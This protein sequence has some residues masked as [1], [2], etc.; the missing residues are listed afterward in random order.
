MLKGSLTLSAAIVLQYVG[1]WRLMGWA[2]ALCA[3]RILSNVLLTRFFK[4]RISPAAVEWCRLS[5]NVSALAGVGVVAGWSL[6]LWI[7]VPFATLWLYGMDGRGRARVVVYLVCM[8]G[9]ALLSGCALIEPVAFSL[10]GVLIFLLTEKRAE[11][12]QQSLEHII[13][14]REQLTQAHGKLRLLHERAFEQEKFSSLGLMAAGVAHEINNPMAFVTSNI[15]SLYKDLHEQQPIPPELLKEYVDEVLPATLDGIK[16]VNA[17]VSDLRHFARGD[18]EVHVEYDL[19]TQARAALRIAQ[20]QLGHVKLELE[21]GEVGLLVG[22]PRQIVQVLV[23]LLV[24]AGQAT[25]RG[26]T[27]R[28]ATHRD[29]ERVRLEVRDTGSGMTRETLHHLFQPF[30]TTKPPGMGTGLG[31]AVAHGI[32]TGQGG[33]IEVESEPGKGSCFTVHLPRVAQRAP[34]GSGQNSPKVF[35]AA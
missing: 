11:L 21:L 23:N 2:F 12:L 16:R 27:V 15:H 3:L 1:Q 24:N 18:A 26:G 4:N 35:A 34:P 13:E 22:R 32:V 25:P 33:R 7:Y 28:L 31:L 20:A 29:G 14:Q 10:V 19:N 5:C 6:L 8:D 9:A 30:F 17:I